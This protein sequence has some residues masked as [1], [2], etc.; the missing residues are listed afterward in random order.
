MRS[1]SG[2]EKQMAAKGINPNRIDP[3]EGGFRS[4]APYLKVRRILAGVAVQEEFEFAAGYEMG[5]VECGRFIVQCETAKR[6]YTC[7]C[8]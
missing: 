7:T 3:S 6:P 8:S 4:S 2:T 5:A 1:Q